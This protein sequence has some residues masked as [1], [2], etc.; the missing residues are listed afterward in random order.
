MKLKIFLSLAI[1]F[2]LK[3]AY[4]E[5][6]YFLSKT[7]LVLP[8]NSLVKIKWILSPD[9]KNKSVETSADKFHFF[10]DYKNEPVILYDNKLLFNPLTGY[11]V[12][13]KN[14]V[15]DVLCLDNGV[16]L[17]SDGS[18]L[19]FIELKKDNDIIP[20]AMIKPIARL[21]MS[22]SKLFRGED[23]VYALAFNKKTKKHEVY[24]FNNSKS[25]FQKIAS[26]NEPLTSLTG[27]GEHLFIASGK[28]IKEFRNGKLSVIYEHPRQ[29]IKEIFYN[30][31]AGLIYKTSNGVGLVKNNA[32]L[33]FLQTEN[34]ML[35][36]KNTS[37]YIFF[38]SASGVLEIMN[39]DDFKNY[40]FKVEK[41]IDI[42]Q[43]FQEELP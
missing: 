24:L 31:K 43:T 21:P 33:E 40:S 8:Q 22:E 39:I 42:K 1:L 27:K 9:L 34:P 30:D 37:L 3:A 28:L 7:L 16:L 26:F 25:V 11:M 10:I 6:N 15:K 32:A 13:F 12:K 35:F 20:T 18:N 4:A 38:S 36:L 23:S 19:G 5:N 41:I 14:P 29:E 2:F 17:F